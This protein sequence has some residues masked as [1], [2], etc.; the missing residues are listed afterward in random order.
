MFFFDNNESN[1]FE[2]I[3]HVDENGSEFWYAREL[4]GVLGYSK[5]QNFEQ[6]VEKAKEACKNSGISTSI[7]FTDVSKT[8]SILDHMGSE[9]LAAN[10]S[11]AAQTDA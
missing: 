9:E 6:I 5:W 10:L 1:S 2:E 3:R 8:S 4:H 7:C 11:S